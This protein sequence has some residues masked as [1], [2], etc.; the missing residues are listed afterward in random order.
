[1]KIVNK[2]LFAVTIVALNISMLVAQN[3]SALE[4]E[5]RYIESFSAI[6]VSGGIDVYLSK[7]SKHEL[8][9]KASSD[10]MEKVITELMGDRLILK[11][12]SGTKWNWKD[13]KSNTPIQIYLTYVDIESIT[14]SGG[15]DIYSQN[16]MSS[17]S[18][19]IKSSGGSDVR[20]DLDVN[21]LICRSSGGSDLDLTGT[22]ED[23]DIVSSGGSDVNAK[24]LKVKDCV[25]FIFRRNQMQKITV[26]GDLEVVASGASDVYIY[27]KPKYNQEKIKRSQ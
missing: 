22:A 18:L 3:N 19:E 16:T 5:N 27:G 25:C 17:Q 2:V 26:S 7:G 9:V 15:S 13:W 8:T 1:M 14:S 24:D 10:V 21:R 20:L 12:K 11:M 6:E 23:V 4:E